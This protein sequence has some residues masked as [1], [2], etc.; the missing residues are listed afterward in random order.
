MPWRRPS[1]AATSSWSARRLELIGAVA[2]T[3]RERAST[4]EDDARRLPGAAAN[5]P[6]HGVDVMTEPY[7]G[8]PTDMQ[9]QIMALMSRSRTAPR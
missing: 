4:V 6:L 8:F 7:P 9:A 3:L 5:G 1:P 2:E